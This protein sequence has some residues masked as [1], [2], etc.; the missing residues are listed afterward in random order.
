MRTQLQR[1]VKTLTT[2]LAVNIFPSGQLSRAQNVDFVMTPLDFDLH[3]P[4]VSCSSQGRS[5]F[6]LTTQLE[7][8]I[9]QSTETLSEPGHA[10]DFPIYKDQPRQTDASL[11]GLNCGIP[12]QGASQTGQRIS[13][14]P[15]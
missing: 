8:N 6:N 9:Y 14:C 5:S 3:G 2:Q 11:N 10:R 4:M 1:F 12:S 7:T 15:R 13:S